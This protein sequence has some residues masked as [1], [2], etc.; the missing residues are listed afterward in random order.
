MVVDDENGKTIDSFQDDYKLVGIIHQ[1]L[2]ESELSK[3]HCLQYIDP[4]GDTTFNMLQKPVLVRELR[5]LQSKCDSETRD[6]LQP[7]IGFL[8]RHEH[9][10]HT[11]VKFYGD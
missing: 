1:T 7:I 5:S 2:S 9:E 4:Y 8:I 3:T 6:Y 11:Y 10:F